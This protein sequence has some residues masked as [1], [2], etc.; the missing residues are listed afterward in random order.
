MKFALSYL[1]PRSSKA[2]IHFQMKEAYAVDDGV[3]G[4]F[5]QSGT[6]KSSLLKALAGLIPNAS[7][8]ISV[9][10]HDY[11]NTNAANNPCVY[12]GADSVLFDHIDVQGNLTLVIKHSE[13]ASKRRMDLHEVSRICA[14]EDLLKQPIV[15]LSSGEKQ[16]VVFARALL[17]G[18]RLVLLDEAFSAL[19]W[20]AR[21]YFIAL[22][23][24]LKALHGMRFIMVSHSL[25]ELALA[26]E[27]IWVLQD[28]KFMV[29]AT[30]NT[31]LDKINVSNVDIEINAHIP[32]AKHKQENTSLTAAEYPQNLTM[33]EYC[34]SLFCVLNIAYIK[35]DELDDQLE[36]WQL[37][38]F[39]DAPAQQIIKRCAHNA[40]VAYGNEVSL[41]NISN[42]VIEADKVS[43]TYDKH[44][45]SSMLNCVD[46]TVIGIDE[47]STKNASLPSGVIIKL[48][49]NGQVIRS[50]ISKRSFAHMK[51]NMGDHLFAIFKAL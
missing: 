27:H 11:Q 8:S 13:S 47:V 2:D 15:A 36:I 46:V 50:L 48:S 10:N 37:P 39:K 6:G 24:K 19:D 49:A 41:Q 31:A 12:V 30:V 21:L 1:I 5:G 32:P 9:D 26:C 16:R 20:P 28:G 7:Y 3:L 43:L 22:V 23:K 35:K 51:I 25:K 38:P 29:Q 17:S 4:I 45:Q 40:K 14:I 33:P 42:I 44:T 34:E 18:K